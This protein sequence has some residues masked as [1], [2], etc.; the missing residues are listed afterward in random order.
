[1]R[2]RQDASDKRAV[3]ADGNP[4]AIASMRPRQD[5][6]DKLTRLVHRAV[7]ADGLQ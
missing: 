6:S 7:E 1:M 3:E 5:A 4:D 2:P